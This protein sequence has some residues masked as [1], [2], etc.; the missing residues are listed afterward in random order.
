MNPPPL[1]PADERWLRRAI[2]LA[3]EAAA[4]GNPP[5]GA[6]VYR[7]EERI[8]EAGNTV[9]TDG[10][11]TRHAEINVIEVAQRLLGCR[12]LA[13]LA[14]AT[15]AEPCP[16]CAGAAHWAG[17]ERIVFGASIPRLRA[18]SGH[19]GRQLEAR[20]AAI[21]APTAVAVLGPALEDEAI[22]VHR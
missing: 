5:F 17:I 13:G 21:L 19:G 8:A 9:R 7:G 18:E 22:A 15:S 1:S 12:D 16:M 10:L 2:A 11:S 3:R 20:C 6:V 4:G 14:L